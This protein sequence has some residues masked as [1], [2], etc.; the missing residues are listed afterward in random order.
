[1]KQKVDYIDERLSVVESQ[2]GFMDFKSKLFIWNLYKEKRVLIFQCGLWFLLT[3][4]I[5]KCLKI[6]MTKIN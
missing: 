5:K 6:F 2:C 3:S 4:F 1:M